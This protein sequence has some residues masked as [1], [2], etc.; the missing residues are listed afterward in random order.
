MSI[1]KTALVLA[2]GSFALSGCA[3][4]KLGRTFND[5]DDVKSEVNA[6]DATTS[7]PTSGSATYTGTSQIAGTFDD[8]NVVVLGDTTM[9]ANFATARISGEITD[10]VGADLNDRQKQRL[11]DGKLGAFAI[12]RVAERG[13]GSIDIK[14]GVIAGNT[15]TAE[16]DGE[17]FMDGLI[18][19]V[20]GGIDGEF[21]GSGAKAIAAED[22][23]D[24]SFSRNGT[25]A[26]SVDAEIYATR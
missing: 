22:G 8:S 1:G 15:F 6:L 19:R 26:T 11:D 5:F 20:G 7:M 3:A 23:A 4:V 18:Y 9:T 25:E 13:D 12:A 2:L 10:L 21:R 14:D 17:F 24:F 16:T